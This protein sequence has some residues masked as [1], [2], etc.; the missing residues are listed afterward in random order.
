MD[1]ADTAADAPLASY[2]YSAAQQRVVAAA[3]NLFARNGVGGT[4]LQMIADAIGVTK[5]AVYHQFKTR[6]DIILAVARTELARLE[7]V[8]AA[9]E[10]AD[11]STTGREV[12]LTHVVNLTVQRRQLVGVLQSDPIMVRFL[13]EHEPFEQLTER[14]F[15]VLLGDSDDEDMRV[16]AAMASAAI[17]GAALHPIVMDLDD[18]ALR[19]HLLHFA[20]RLFQ[21]PE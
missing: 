4:S 13:A 8:I 16:Q 17:G 3:L 9:A 20:R 14:L 10:A 21:L 19:H 6:D 11:N 1:P 12:L 15:R 5:A 18:D 7:Q 2:S